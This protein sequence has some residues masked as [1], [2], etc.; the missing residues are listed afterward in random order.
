MTNICVSGLTKVSQ[1]SQDHVLP[2]AFEERRIF[3][4][5]V[6]HLSGRVARLH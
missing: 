3:R 6:S 1:G 2:E 4:R 5:D